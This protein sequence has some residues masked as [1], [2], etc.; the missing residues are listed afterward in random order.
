MIPREPRTIFSSNLA[1]SLMSTPS[2]SRKLIVL[3][4]IVP[5]EPNQRPLTVNSLSPKNA[6]RYL[7]HI[8][9]AA[10]ARMRVRYLDEINIPPRD[11][12]LILKVDETLR[13][14]A[15]GILSHE[16]MEGIY[17][18]YFHGVNFN[19]VVLQRY[20]QLLT[21]S[22]R[23]WTVTL[24]IT[25]S[26]VKRIDPNN[27]TLNSWIDVTNANSRTEQRHPD[28]APSI[29]DIQK[30]RV[31]V[32]YIPPFCHSNVLDVPNP[33]PPLPGTAY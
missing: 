29:H 31:Y 21:P 20:L 4:G 28:T 32:S 10:L 18:T 13:N 1:T 22:I 30:Q 24:N 2:S 11:E 19:T 5:R 7:G 14:L 27:Y 33:A 9:P 15:G 8:P 17:H 23:S 6:L 26:S 25:Y 16:V 3:F 12:N